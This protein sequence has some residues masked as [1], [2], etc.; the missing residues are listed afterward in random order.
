MNRFYQL[1]YNND[2]KQIITMI[3][4]LKIKSHKNKKEWIKRDYKSDNF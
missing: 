2:N 3:I 4:N 1:T